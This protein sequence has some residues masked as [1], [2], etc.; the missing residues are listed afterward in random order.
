[1]TLE[2]TETERLTSLY[3]K[4]AINVK[5]NPK[6]LNEMEQKLVK[7]TNK[8]TRKVI[9]YEEVNLFEILSKKGEYSLYNTLNVMEINQLKHIVRKYCLDSSKRAER[10]KNKERLVK[11]ITEKVIVQNDR[12]KV[13]LTY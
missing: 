3:Q 9:K 1:M 6:I 4:I 2:K 12:G 13:F 7:L 8:N 10:W 5:K 11:Y